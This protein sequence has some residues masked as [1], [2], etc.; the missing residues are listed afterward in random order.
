[1]AWVDRVR[2]SLRLRIGRRIVALRRIGRAAP[3]PAAA[4]EQ[5]G[6]APVDGPDP[7]VVAGCH[8]SGTSLVR[9]ILDS[10]SRIACPPEV[11]VFERLAPALRGPEAE[12]G[13]AAVGVTVDR[14]AAEL[15]AV[16]H[17]WLAAYAASK[18]K[19]RWAEKSPGTVFV[20][21]E[22]DRMFGGRARFVLVSRDGM[23]VACSLGK[24]N[25]SVLEDLTARHGD[26]YVAAAHHWSAATRELLAFHRAVPDRSFLLRYEELVV[27]PEGVLRRLFAFLGEAWEPLVLDFNRFEHDTGLE[28]HVVGSTWR[29]E[30]GRGKH[31]ALPPD[32]QARLWTIVRPGMLDLGYPDRAFPAG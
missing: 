17:R 6:V 22:V 29:V 3:G 23:D 2:T 19:V 7:I 10:H 4:V 27:D 16:T 18:G 21:P 32:L 15:G 11:Q 26:P 20:L 1:M 8:R 31:K 28:D 12:K 24:G 25:W 9:R 14:A 30:D 5:P 13:L